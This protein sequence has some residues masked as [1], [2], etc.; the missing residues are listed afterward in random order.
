MKRYPGIAPF[1]QEDEPV[2]FGRERETR[3]VTNLIMAQKMLVLFAK[4]GMGK[5]SLLNAGVIPALLKNG[6]Y[7][8]SIR[9]NEI[10][11]DTNNP[12]ER[13][14]A[15]YKRAYTD[16]MGTDKAFADKETIWQTLC[17]NQLTRHKRI[18][19]PV[20]IFDQFE[21]FFRTYPRVEQRAAFLRQLADLASDVI[22]HGNPTEGQKALLNG[23]VKPVN[24]RMVFSIRADLLD[25]MQEVS[26]YIPFVLR[27]RYQLHAM[28]RPQLDQAIREPGLI[29]NKAYPTGLIRFDDPVI[30]DILNGL[31]QPRQAVTP[32]DFLNEPAQT[33][34]GDIRYGLQQSRQSD[35]T[36]PNP[37]MTDALTEFRDESG[38]VETFELQ[39]VCG[40][41]ET[42]YSEAKQSELANQAIDV[43]ELDYGGAAGIQQINEVY[44]KNAIIE[45]VEKG[46]Q[47][48][49]PQQ[50]F[51]DR[52]HE[53]VM[54]KKWAID[55][56]RHP[57]M[58][59][60][61]T[62]LNA[63]G[64]R[65]L[66]EDSELILRPDEKRDLE[67]RRLLT[68]E[69]IE[70]TLYYKVSHDKIALAIYKEKERIREEQWADRYR[71]LFLLGL[72]LVGLFFL[73]ALG[74]GLA[75]WAKGRSGGDNHSN[76]GKVTPV[77]PTSGTA[78][79]ASASTNATTTTSDTSSPA[80]TSTTSTT[81][82]ASTSL[83][84]SASATTPTSGTD[85]TSTNIPPGNAPGSGG[86]PLNP[87][88][89]TSA[90]TIIIYRLYQD[91]LGEA[92]KEYNNAIAL[93]KK[94]L[95]NQAETSLPTNLSPDIEALIQNPALN[96]KF[97]NLR[98]Q[99]NQARKI[100]QNLKPV[101]QLV[102]QAQKYEE[103]LRILCANCSYKSALDR[104]RQYVSQPGYNAYAYKTDR[105][106]KKIR[107]TDQAV[108]EGIYAGLNTKKNGGST[109]ISLSNIYDKC[110]CP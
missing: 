105:L 25:Q 46:L 27:G 23:N 1:Q 108:A 60:L 58:Q 91:Q 85:S 37:V 73:V 89:P 31:T 90:Q 74:E 81:N 34:V 82:T 10:E 55:R 86:L 39:L 97:E 67:E 78:S 28:Q 79:P 22:P 21:E 6:L 7:P 100:C 11:N 57:L 13:F 77:T 24:L 56:A 19:V 45:I 43:Q 110:G 103:D 15:L 64:N 52:L 47:Q 75:L 80:S 76:Q 8:I 33:L 62:L 26:Y 41:L 69:K 51:F 98:R 109:S 12:V 61:L 66:R 106:T 87:R 65:I 9:F 93:M 94:Q 20:L 102:E 96:Q 16:F 83:P 53:A 49:R 50:G 18:I 101:Q 63:N 92:Q 104:Q 70:D 99:V 44:F 2:F 95:F 40:Y 32:A 29:Q 4:S 35:T 59:Q 42:K 48:T 54:G 107:A 84:A 17:W 30:T 38:D 36:S 72:L 71:R 14:K 88:T 68:S 5:T 3:E